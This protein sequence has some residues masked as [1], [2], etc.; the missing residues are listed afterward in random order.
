[1]TEFGLIEFAA[2]LFSDVDRHG[3]EAIGDD[4][5]VMPVGDGDVVA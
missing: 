4:C 2:R 3:W 5:T 1:M